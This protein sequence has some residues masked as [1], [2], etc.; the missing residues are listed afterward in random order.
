[1]ERVLDITPQE[2]R[3]VAAARLVPH[4]R[5]VL[6]YEPTAP[7]AADAPDTP[8]DEDAKEQQQ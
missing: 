1:V 6:V 8:D 7:E 4:N 3:A 2:V 5:A